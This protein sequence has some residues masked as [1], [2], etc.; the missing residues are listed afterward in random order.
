[1]R[2]LLLILICTLMLSAAFQMPTLARQSDSS[3]EYTDCPFDVPQGETLGN[4]I[5]CGYF[6]VP[7][8][9]ADPNSPEIYLAVAILYANTDSPAPDPVIY[10]AG[11]LAPARCWRSIAGWKIP[12]VSRDII[13]LDQRGTGYSE[14]SLSCPDAGD[15]AT[16]AEAASLSRLLGRSGRESVGVQ[17]HPVRCRRGGAA[18]SAGLRRVESVR[19]FLWHAAGA[20]D[21]PRQPDGRAQRNLDSTYPPQVNDQE[22]ASS[23]EVTTFSVLFNG[24]AAD[25]VCNDAYP[26]L[27]NVFY[28]TVDQ[29]N[30]QPGEYVAT[31]PATGEESDATLSG[32][33]L[34]EA[35][36]QA[37]YVTG[38]IPYLPAMIYAVSEGDYGLLDDI[39][40]GAILDSEKAR[41]PTRRQDEPSDDADA[42]F[43]SVTCSEEIPFNDY[44]ASIADAE[45]TP[46][47]VRDGLVG[48]ESMFQTCEIWDVT[49][50]P[51]FEAE[52]VV[53]DLPVLVLAGEYDPATPPAWGEIAAETLSNSFFFEF[54]GVGH[55]TIDG[56]DCPRSIFLAFLDDPT[57]EPDASCIAEMTPPE[58]VVIQ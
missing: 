14:P 26:D 51:E 45:S 29:L 18:R 40:S 44:E 31:D 6:L 22:E 43:N 35:L 20:G 5:D 49:P 17:Q 3:F 55:G 21:D 58:F 38:N 7:E 13:L 15:N 32:D 4:S 42:M 28:Q 25:S 47:E 27:E 53:S 1:M 37:M 11:G 46:P 50:A 52:P 36:Y 9:Y 56:G 41:V 8:D 24:C 16:D 39:N 19:R 2:R 48:V 33:G 34:V 12:F 10:L 23:D 30:S 57:T 54:P